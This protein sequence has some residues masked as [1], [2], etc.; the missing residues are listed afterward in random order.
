MELNLR[1]KS[2]SVKYNIGYFFSWIRP[3]VKQKTPGLEKP[4]RQGRRLRVARAKFVARDLDSISFFSS[5]SPQCPLAPC[6]ARARDLRQ[7]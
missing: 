1:P 2:G 4:T 6:E 3:A 7:Q 5:N